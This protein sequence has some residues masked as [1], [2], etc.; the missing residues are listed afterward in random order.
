MAPPQNGGKDS[1]DR[2]KPSRMPLLSALRHVATHCRAMG[3][4]L[5]TVCVFCLLCSG[6]AQCSAHSQHYH[7]SDHLHP[8]KPPRED[9]TQHGEVVGGHGLEHRRR[10]EAI[11]TSAKDIEEM[12]FIKRVFDKFGNG[13]TMTLEGFELLLRSLGLERLVTESFGGNIEDASSPAIT[14]VANVNVNNVSAV[15]ARVSEAT[16][17]TRHQHGNISKCLKA[18]DL[19]S[20][21]SSHIHPS[22]K[23]PNGSKDTL[24]QASLSKLCPSLLY[25]LTAVSDKERT[26]GCVATVP[27]LSS[28]HVEVEKVEETDTTLVWLYSSLSILVIS[29]CGLLGV[30]VIPFMQKVF[31]HQLLQ[32]LV[33]LAVGTLCGDALLHLLPHAM[34]SKSESHV[35]SD[36]TDSHAAHDLNMWK[37]LVAALGVVFFFFTEKCL[38]LVAEWRKTV[39]KKRKVPPSRVHVMRDVEGVGMAASVGEKLCKHKYSS[40]P[41]CYGE[42]T[43]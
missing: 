34:S 13:E 27:L 19:F 3:S 31:Y 30:A 15:N 1:A 32:F 9:P 42:I 38:T 22:N 40:Y 28:S 21:L 14:N 25:Q 24:S 2:I 39:Q 23:I 4:P 17:D 12:Y 43:G 5:V 20:S 29:L 26:A 6:H 18:Q 10:R 35:H 36:G 37:G 11:L 16:T 8:F 7:D 41:Y 33:A